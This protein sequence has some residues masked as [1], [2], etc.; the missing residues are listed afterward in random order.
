M[1][2]IACIVLCLSTIVSAEILPSS[3]RIDWGPGIPGG[4]PEPAVSVSVAD[5][6]AAAD[7]VTDDHDAF[8]AAI[9]ALP[10]AGGAVLV[11]EGTYLI[12]ST[13]SLPSGVVLRGEGAD[14]TRLHFSQSDGSTCIEAITY[15]RGEWVDAV[16]G[17][18]PGSTE[19]VVA[20]GS[21]FQAGGFAE[22][23]QDNDPAVM[24]TDSKWSQSWA[25]GSVGQILVIDKVNGNTLT[26]A[27]PLYSTY[28]AE[29]NPVVRSQGLVEKAGVEKLFVKKT[30][31]DADGSTFHFKNTAYCWVREVESDHT[32]KSHVNVTASI[33]CV[34]RDSYFHHSYDHGGGG[35]GY[36]VNLGQHVTACLVENNIFR[37]L[38]HSMLVQVG[39]TGNVFGYNYSLDNVQGAGETDMN[40]GWTPCDISLHGHYPSYNLFEGN[41]VQEIDV[42]DYWGPCGPG[43]TFL[44]NTVESEGIDVLDHSHQQNVIGNVLGGGA[45]DL[46]IESG[47]ENT[48]AH[49]NVIGGTTEWDTDIADHTIPSSYYLNGKPAFFGN[50]SWPAAGP[51]I[52]APA[53]LPAKERYDSGD[54]VT[55]T[56][57]PLCPHGAKQRTST[58][59]RQRCVLLG[60]VHGKVLRSAH[61]L[62]GRVMDLHELD[63]SAIQQIA[64]I[65]EQ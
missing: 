58:P 28:R 21:S 22:I 5:H 46:T 2:A 20:D 18:T 49:G 24:Y 59:R 31:P 43:N 33:G 47:V 39:A 45:N 41:V 38:R 30:V 62:S 60:Q 10:S 55:R 15:Q 17:Y 9:D 63:R 13:I 3:R 29:L 27:T 7:G 32:R 52:S 1:R 4:I 36:G 12:G 64:V 11:P 19:L 23:Q 48:L 51:G 25:E 50:T 16:S 44:R 37:H 54:F 61:S 35:H 65:L 53:T 56:L 14:K 8:A 57:S 34:F 26:L 40:Q 6:G 42:S